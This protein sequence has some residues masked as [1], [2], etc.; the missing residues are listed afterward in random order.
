MKKGLAIAFQ[1]IGLFLLWMVLAVAILYGLT[2]LWYSIPGMMSAG[3]WGVVATAGGHLIAFFLTGAFILLLSSHTV[4]FAILGACVA[5]LQFLLRM[6]D[7]S[8]SNTDCGDRCVA[9]VLPRVL[10]DE[11]TIAT[12]VC[13]VVGYTVLL[14]VAKHVK[15]RTHRN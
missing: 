6:F 1:S 11:A 2:N 5:G 12:L 14:F 9:E 8:I 4:Q 3:M 15:D 10:Q 7:A 13:L